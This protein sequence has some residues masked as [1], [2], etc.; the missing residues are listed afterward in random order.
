FSDRQLPALVVAFAD[1][2]DMTRTLR[3]EVGEEIQAELIWGDGVS[4]DELNLLYE[5]TLP[6]S[7]LSGSLA[8]LAGSLVAGNPADVSQLMRATSVDF[9]LLAPGEHPAR[10]EAEVALSTLAVLQSSGE[11]EFGTLYRL[12]D[13]QPGE[14]DQATSDFAAIQLG[15]LVAYFLLSIPTPATVRGY[16]KVRSQ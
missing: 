4:Q 12:D 16:R 6:D 8:Q 13:L 7:P 15:L 3:L 14:G 10:A 9:V 5:Q 2:D 1:V 11:S